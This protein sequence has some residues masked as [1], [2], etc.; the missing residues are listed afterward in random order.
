[1]DNFPPD[2]K[3]SRAVLVI[4]GNDY[5]NSG[6]GGDVTDILNQY[7]DLINST[8]SIA[9]S[10]TVSSICPRNRSAEV[11]ERISSLNAGIHALCSD[12]DIEYADNNPSFY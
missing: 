7:K 1:M 11:T 3:L 10:I 2:R 6:A 5:D 8:K 12:L 4:G 9:N